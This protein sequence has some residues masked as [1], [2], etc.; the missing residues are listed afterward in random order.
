MLWLQI[1]V[2]WLH[3]LGGIFWFGGLLYASVIL[4]PLMRSLDPPL[5]ATVFGGTARR[6]GPIIEVVGAATIALGVVRGTFLG[7]VR[8]VEF[9]LATPYGVT[10][11]V[12][13]LLG[14]GILAWS[15]FV[16]FPAGLRVAAGMAKGETSEMERTMPLV[17]VEMLAFF[18]LFTCMILMRFGL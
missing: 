8:S 11:G 17:M 3:V 10:W 9:L 5:A 7:P 2:T 14:L 18:A 13:L 12:A 4:A 1:T 15:H 6:A 16:I